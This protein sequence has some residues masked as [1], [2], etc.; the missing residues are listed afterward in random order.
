MML[1]G[2]AGLGFA[3]RQ[4]MPGPPP[5]SSMNSMP[6]ARSIKNALTVFLSKFVFI[7]LIALTW[8]PLESG[9]VDEGKYKSFDRRALDSEKITINLGYVD[10]GQMDL[11]PYTLIGIGNMDDSLRLRLLGHD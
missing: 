10:L 3:F 4:S 5:F 2:F 7:G 8:I 11:L 6:A 9:N 1:I